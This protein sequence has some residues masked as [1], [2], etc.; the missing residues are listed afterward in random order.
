MKKTKYT[1]KYTT[2]L[3]KD[4]KRAI[5]R[6]LKIELLEQIVALLAMVGTLRVSY[7]TRLATCL[8][9]RK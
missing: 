9:Y 7:S 1:I 3:K 2:S 6:G 8:S 5:K 4:Y